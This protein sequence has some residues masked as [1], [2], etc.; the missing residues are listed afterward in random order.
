MAYFAAID[1]VKHELA[2]Q[3]SIF[4]PNVG[5][6][7]MREYNFQ[8]GSHALMI[9]KAGMILAPALRKMRREL[10]FSLPASIGDTI[11]DGSAPRV[12]AKWPRMPATKVMRVLMQAPQVLMV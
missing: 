9:I 6:I 1:A 7:E 11:P 2:D 8:V 3:A 10:K 4:L 12:V 5:V